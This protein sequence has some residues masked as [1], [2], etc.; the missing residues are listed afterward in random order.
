VNHWNRLG[1]V[2]SILLRA[3][4]VISIS[5]AM[6]EEAG[7]LPVSMDK[8]DDQPAG[9]ESNDVASIEKGISCNNQ[10]IHKNKCS[11][12]KSINA[13]LEKPKQRHIKFP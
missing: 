8:G 3:L 7:K 1:G 9:G 10:D 6:A 2:D 5:R 13:N 12:S 4:K 11:F